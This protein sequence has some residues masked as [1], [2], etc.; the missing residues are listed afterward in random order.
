LILQKKLEQAV[1]ST[2]RKRKPAVSK[3]ARRI[4]PAIKA[5]DISRLVSE[6][7]E[8]DLARLMPELERIDALAAEAIRALVEEQKQREEDDLV[9]ILLMAA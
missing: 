9:S 7:A 1:K 5:R 2:P 4:A 8:K 3:A 6:Q